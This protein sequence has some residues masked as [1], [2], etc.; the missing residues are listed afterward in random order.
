MLTAD[1][2]RLSTLTGRFGVQVPA[3]QLRSTVEVRLPDH[4]VRAQQHRRRQSQSDL[5]RCAD[6]DH[7]TELARRQIGMSPGFAPFRT[8]TMYAAT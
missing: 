3:I 5:L 4:L 8:V 6:V 7:E 1:Q 2:G